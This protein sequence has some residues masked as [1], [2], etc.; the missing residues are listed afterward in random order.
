MELQSPVE[1]GRSL[2]WPMFLFILLFHFGIGV[3]FILLQQ[4]VN[5]GLLRRNL[6]IVLFQSLL[7][8]DGGDGVLVPLRN[9]FQRLHCLCA[10]KVLDAKMV[11]GTISW[12]PTPAPMKQQISSPIQL[13]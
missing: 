8:S 10:L 6:C 1:R 3:A 4:G 9:A 13:Q 7:V 2:E 5:F 11:A 12:S